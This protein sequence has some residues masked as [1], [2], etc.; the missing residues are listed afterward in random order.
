M[1]EPPQVCA[2]DPY[3]FPGPNDPPRE[4]VREEAAYARDRDRLVRDHLGK[5]VA[6][7]L[8]IDTGSKRSSLVPAVLD[9]LK[10]TPFKTVRVRTSLTGRS[11]PAARFSSSRY[12]ICSRRT[13]RRLFA[14][15]AQREE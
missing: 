9:Q 10:P 15:R 4:W 6:V 7:R 8:I 12:H 1:N 14:Q 2:K 11:F 13:E 5:F 3:A